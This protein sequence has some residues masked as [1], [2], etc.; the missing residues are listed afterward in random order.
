MVLHAAAQVMRRILVDQARMRGAAKRGGDA[1]TLVLDEAVALP[2][3]NSPGCK[4]G[5]VSKRV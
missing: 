1:V 2:R 3:T 5:C 4:S